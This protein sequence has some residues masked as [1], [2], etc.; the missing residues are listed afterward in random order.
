MEHEI[1]RPNF[2]LL[3]LTFECNNRC[4]WCYESPQ[5]FRK[6]MMDGKSIIR[7]LGLCKSLGIKDVGFLGGEPTMHPKLFRMLKYASGLGLRVSLYTNGRRLSDT[8]FVKKLKDSGVY[9]VNIGVQSADPKKHDSITGVGG[10]Y[11]ETVKGIENCYKNGIRFRLLSVMCCA[12]FK[13]YSGIIDKFAYMKRTFVFF[14]ETPPVNKYRQQEVL[15]NRK[16]ARL[17]EKLYN[18]S[19]IAGASVSFYIRMPLCWF[20]KPIADDMVSNN[21]LENFCH[22]SDGLSLNIDV[23]GNLLPCVNW[24]GYHMFNLQSN[25]MIISKK[26][27][28]NKWNSEKME[29]IRNTLRR[30]PSK[31][32]VHCSHY[33]INCRGGCPLIKFKLGPFYRQYQ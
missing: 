12:D 10:S 22:V 23:D 20:K 7:Y 21:A 13:T 14:R 33:G 28:L 1:D 4:R 18:H 2:A 24:A 16:T 3:N 26:G 15:D 29:R 17:I 27:F 8:L 25:G 6:G 31:E 19:K 5:G 30:Y 32:C 11:E 9:V